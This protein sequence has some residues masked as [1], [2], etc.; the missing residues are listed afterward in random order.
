MRKRKIIQTIGL[1][2]TRRE[3]RDENGTPCYG[4]TMF[5]KYDDNRHKW[6]R[7]K[8]QD[9]R[10]IDALADDKDCL[11]NEVTKKYNDPFYGKVEVRRYSH[12][13]KYYERYP[14]I[15]QSVAESAAV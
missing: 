7:I 4:E 11:Y 3:W 5:Y 1:A 6:I 2:R 14:S 8:A 12:W 9:Y 15:E 10:T 13:C